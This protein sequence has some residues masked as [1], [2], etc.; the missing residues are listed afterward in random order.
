M[1]A[2]TK[3][4]VTV[5]H[6]AP[7][8]PGALDAVRQH[9]LSINKP[10]SFVKVLE[11]WAGKTSNPA[12]GASVLVEAAQ[13]TVAHADDLPRAQSAIERAV[14]IDPTVA[15]ITPVID[16]AY[17]GDARGRLKILARRIE[18]LRAQRASPAI[19]SEAYAHYGTTLASLGRV[20]KALEILEPLAAR[21][22]DAAELVVKLLIHRADK[23]PGTAARDRRRAVQVLRGSARRSPDNA[24]PL[25]MRA[26][27][28]VPTDEAAM[29]ELEAV[30][31]ADALIPYWDAFI[32]QSTGG[33]AERV[34][35]KLARAKGAAGD[36]LGAI[37]LLEPLAARVPEAR[38]ELEKLRA[39]SR[40]A[41]RVALLA[42]LE[43]ELG[44]ASSGNELDSALDDFFDEDEETQVGSIQQPAKGGL[45]ALKPDSLP[46]P[47]P[48]GSRPPAAKSSRPPPPRRA[49]SSLP[50]PL[51]SANQD[52][53]SIK[54]EP[55]PSALV[56]SVAPMTMPP[57]AFD[58]F[59]DYEPLAESDDPPTRPTAKAIAAPSGDDYDDA[60]TRMARRRAPAPDEFFKAPP[61]E[62]PLADS[63][64]ADRTPAGSLLPL[65]ELESRSASAPTS[66]APAQSLGFRPAA[67]APFEED[68][69]ETNE[70]MVNIDPARVVNAGEDSHDGPFTAE[71]VR[72]VGETVHEVQVL[73][74]WRRLAD[75]AFP[76]KIR[77]R[78]DHATVTIDR[79]TDG[80][81]LTRANGQSENLGTSPTA[82]DIASG[83]R[84][85]VVRGN[86][87]WFVRGGHTLVDAK[88]NRQPLDLRTY[89]LGIGIAVGVH[90]V[91]GILVEMLTVAGVVNLAVDDRPREEI[92]AEARLRPEKRPPPPRPRPRRRPRQEKAPPP[93][94]TRTTLS[95][96]LRRRM[97]QLQRNT[98]ATSDTERLVERLTTP[99]AGA[100]ESISEVVTSIDGV[101]AAAHVAGT[102]GITGSLQA[103][104]G[105]QVAREAGSANVGALGGNR[106][107]FYGHDVAKA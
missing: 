53:L 12:A 34:T 99:N 32:A 30:A 28:I 36:A 87:R 9:L 96:T 6:G 73:R 26:L 13:L 81:R 45:P 18:L 31:P 62:S 48:L 79:E 82:V 64:R 105:I 5:L 27:Q 84:L 59:E 22:D 80:L 97:R 61:A 17:A 70:P 11:W 63:A 47:K 20:D 35:V 4:L 39:T 33:P 75:R 103:V 40:D 49:I 57:G 102:A 92:F 50:P 76:G 56:P 23:Q 90:L 100:A 98:R 65:D 93:R 89:G 21:R 91:F 104:E 38:N 44:G 3:E 37:A 25:L 95:K 14:E 71:V 19:R 7:D 2:K 16:E 52:S 107:C 8:R 24:A 78:G 29:R 77:I 60:K 1:D 69:E 46:P 83:A 55:I 68:D 74:G 85:E 106:C 54:S 66:T 67:L 42:E 51:P 15:G 58:N 41:S 88:Q 43:A 101:A 10:I 94:E 72:M 86:L